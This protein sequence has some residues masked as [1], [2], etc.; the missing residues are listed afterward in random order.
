M[1]IGNGSFIVLGGV[2][3]KEVNEMSHDDVVDCLGVLYRIIMEVLIPYTL[4]RNFKEE[5][6]DFETIEAFECMLD[7]VEAIGHV[8][9]LYDVLVE[10]PFLLLSDYD[11]ESLF[12]KLLHFSR[13]SSD[14]SYDEDDLVNLFIKS[15]KE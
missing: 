4:Q 15:I 9:E 7:E 1:V 10:K 6:K 11:L 2:V 14:K 12:K 13:E 5:F 3:M 8:I